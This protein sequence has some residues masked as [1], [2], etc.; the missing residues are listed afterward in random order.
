MQF[1]VIGCS[2]GTGQDVTLT[3][4]A[5][6]PSAAQIRGNE[7]GV[8]VESVVPVE[9]APMPYAVPVTAPASVVAPMRGGTPSKSS[10]QRDAEFFGR[11]VS[12]FTGSAK[13]AVA[14]VVLLVIGSCVYVILSPSIEKAREI[15]Q[16]EG[17]IRDTASPLP[18]LRTPV[19][20]V[21]ITISAIALMQE[22]E[23][24]ELAAKRRFKNK[25]TVV[26]GLVDSVG[27]D[28]LGDP[29]IALETN[30]LIGVVQCML[31]PGDSDARALAEQLEPGAPVCLTGKVSGTF[32]NVILRECMLPSNEWFEER[33]GIEQTIAA[34]R[35]E[36]ATAP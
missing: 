35:K 2:R 9:I 36:P 24:N 19:P 18:I 15:T 32:I 21:V 30:S 22:Y 27:E 6:T 11:I 10:W 28:L 12:L 3:L 20:R 33:G 31:H 17:T 1:R 16:H 23:T 8:L 7:L 29:F 26:T 4:E 5:P 13:I 25:Y 14:S 34:V